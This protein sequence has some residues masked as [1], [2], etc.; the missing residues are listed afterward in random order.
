MHLSSDRAAP[1]ASV[2]ASAVALGTWTE[3][4]PAAG[5]SGLNLREVLEYRDLM[6]I[7]A[8]RDLKVRYRQTVFGVA[9][10]VLQPV[11]AMAILSIFLGRLAKVPSNHLPY[12]LFVF[13]GLV[14][15]NYCATAVTSSAGSL[16]EYR[17]LVTKVWFPRLIAP[18]AAILPALVD[19]MVSVV[20]VLVLLAIYGR[21]PPPTIV[22]MPLWVVGAMVV[23]AAV[24]VWLAAAN[25]LYRDV[26][27]ILPVAIQLWLFLSPV[28][29]P[30][31]LVHGVERY[32][33]ALNPLVGVIDGF[34]W[35]LVHGPAPP[36]ADLVSVISALVLLASGLLYFGRVDRH[37][38]DRI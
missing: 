38:A 25:A 3:N 12:P 7:L 16:V 15:W 27:Y 19:M 22:L 1:E 30:S 14:G 35:S 21:V 4:R 34:R 18:L 31:S 2:T 11:L 9:W 29:Y 28:L 37:L 23:A 24:G 8:L 13:A 33:Y 32:V 10:A 26:R 20:V 6:L 36:A 5:W 17:P